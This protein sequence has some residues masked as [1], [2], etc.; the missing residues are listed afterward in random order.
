MDSYNVIANQPVVIDNVSSEL[1]CM[2][3]LAAFS[4]TCKFGS[5]VRQFRLLSDHIGKTFVLKQIQCFSS[6][7]NCSSTEDLRWCAQHRYFSGA[8]LAG[9]EVTGYR[10]GHE[11]NRLGMLNSIFFISR[12]VCAIV[13]HRKTKT[14]PYPNW[15]R[16]RCSDPNVRIQKFIHY[17]TTPQWVFLQNSMRIEFAHTHQHIT[18]DIRF[19]IINV[20]SSACRSCVTVDARRRLCTETGS[21]PA[22]TQW[23]C[24]KCASIW[25]A[26]SGKD[27]A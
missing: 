17:M 25:L 10:Q 7:Q 27:A 3:I 9:S 2:K 21:D 6:I 15:Y 8:E 18:R 5:Q 19:V 24:R 16:R 22:A 1:W 26:T 14:N 20:A 13:L 4:D 23:N 11:W 12:T